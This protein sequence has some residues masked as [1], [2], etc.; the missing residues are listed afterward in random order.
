LRVSRA[1]APFHHLACRLPLIRS[2]SSPG[3]SGMCMYRAGMTSKLA[4]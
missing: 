4:E 1:G 3:A 2:D